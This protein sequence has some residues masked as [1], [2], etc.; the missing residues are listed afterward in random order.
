MAKSPPLPSSPRLNARSG[1]VPSGRSSGSGTTS[2]SCSPPPGSW[3]TK[4]S[5]TNCHSLLGGGGKWIKSSSNGGSGAIQCGGGGGSVSV[6]DLATAARRGQLFPAKL[7]L[8][9]GMISTL[10]G[11]LLVAFGALALWEQAAMAYLGSGNN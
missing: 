7:A 3:Q 2:A 5:A 1:A 8:A 10:L 9:L 4:S 11:V 6:D